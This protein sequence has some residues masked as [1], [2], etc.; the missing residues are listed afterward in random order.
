[1]T[2]ATLMNRPRSAERGSATV[3]MLAVIAA[4]LTLTVSGLLLSCAV[5][6]SHRAR[7]AADLA[8]LA[9]AGALLQGEPSAAACQS[10]EVVATANHGRLQRCLGVGM[11]VWITIAVPAGMR[12]FGVATARSR[13]G[14]GPGVGPGV[15]LSPSR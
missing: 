12:G 2:P 6:A 1:V 11:D 3:V 14:P 15:G 8:A 10:A 5:L 4:V 9:A 7:A 13:A